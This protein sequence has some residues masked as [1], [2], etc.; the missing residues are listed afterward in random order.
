MSENSPL[1]KLVCIQEVKSIIKLKVKALL[2]HFNLKKNDKK[3]E[4]FIDLKFKGG[5]TRFLTFFQ[6]NVK[7]I[8]FY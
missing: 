5:S 6:K 4:T 8:I 3:T 7:M 2:I 1:K